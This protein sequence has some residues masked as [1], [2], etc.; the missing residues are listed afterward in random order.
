MRLSQDGYGKNLARLQVLWPD[1]MLCNSASGP[2]RTTPPGVQRKINRASESGTGGISIYILREIH[3]FSYIYIYILY[4]F[5]YIHVYRHL[6]S[7]HII[8]HHIISYDV[9]SYRIISYR[10]I[11]HIFISYH[12]ISYHIIALLNNI[13][14][15]QNPAK[16]ADVR[17]GSTIA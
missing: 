16:K 11:S 12:T 8:P 2:G 17:P 6:L 9:I 10:I 3:I 4:T 5:I 15:G 1:S 14:S 7:Y 13:E